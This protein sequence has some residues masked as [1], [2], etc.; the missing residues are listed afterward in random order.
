MMVA[1]KPE[2]SFDQVAAPVLEIMDGSLYFSLELR[3]GT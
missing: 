1:S 3:Y 2:V